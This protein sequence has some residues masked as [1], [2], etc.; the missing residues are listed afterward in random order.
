MVPIARTADPRALE[1]WSFALE[2]LALPYELAPGDDEGSE[3][4]VW[5]REEHAA[6]AHRAVV[7][8]DLE[9]D[10]AR[11]RP[12][13]PPPE[14]THPNGLAW[15]LG[16]LWGL[17]VLS[18]VGFGSASWTSSGMLDARAFEA[19]DWFRVVT[20]ITL[21]S[22][23]AHLASN[24]L[25][26]AVLAPAAIARLGPGVGLALAL[27]CG[28]LA[29]LASVALHPEGYRAVGASGMVFAFL[30]LI[31]G[32]AVRRST[33][34]GIRRWMPGAG[35]ALGLFAWMGVAPGTDVV[36]HFG[37]CA[38]GFIAGLAVPDGGEPDSRTERRR[39][40]VAGLGSA[41]VVALAWIRAVV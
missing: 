21:H 5:V 25:L 41:A 31:A 11:D 34:T 17:L 29:N 35:A 6:E 15:A 10:R 28:V 37:G 32:L 38:F 1:R 22:D 27:G 30:G 39:Q 18:L 2:A 19:G 36:A 9:E 7:E 16:F 26:F 13:E 24:G 12:P 33:A 20:A 8:L 4:V 14:P 23:V 40:Q 3:V